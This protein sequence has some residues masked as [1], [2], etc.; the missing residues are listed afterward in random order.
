MQRILSN[1]TYI[2]VFPNDLARYY[3]PAI[4]PELHRTFLIC[5]L[6]HLL[7]WTI[8]ED[9]GCEYHHRHYLKI[10]I[11]SILGRSLSFFLYP[12]L[13]ALATHD[14]F[15]TMQQAKLAL[16]GREVSSETEK[17]FCRDFEIFWNMA[18]QHLDKGF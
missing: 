6:L 18:N 2:Y 10:A 7:F 9:T 4:P 13:L 12:E 14:G 5:T 3:I 8:F 11:P 16:P 17:A 15:L 1:A